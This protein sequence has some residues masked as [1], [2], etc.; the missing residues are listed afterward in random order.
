MRFSD[1]MGRSLDLAE[2]PLRL[3]S[4]VPSQSEFLW[5][6]GLQ[7][8][9]VGITKFCVHPQTM[10]NSV[11]RVGG[12]KTPDIA[13]IRA[14]K[15][16]LIIGNKE[17][18]DE[19]SIALLEKEFPVWMSDIHSIDK[20]SGMMLELGRISGREKEAGALLMEVKA[21]VEACHNLFRGERVAYLIWKEP[22]MLAGG[23][24]F[25]NSIL[26]HAG[27]QNVAAHLPRYPKL[28][29]DELRELKPERCFLSSEPYPFTDKHV[30]AFKGLLPDCE[31]RL[32]DGEAFSWYGSR[33]RYL[34]PYLN[35]LKQ[36]LY[37]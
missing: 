18:N 25:I 33:L 35:Q 9:L 6:L 12:T 24:T 19:Q 20:A 26:E 36:S 8:E 21:S 14:L 10:F 5:D 32:V 34:Y 4:L 37:A 11:T 27:F 7:K 17:E 23:Q 1:Q 16:D 3:V 22:L 15:P 28:T 29:A 31:P 13:K 30:L 2:K